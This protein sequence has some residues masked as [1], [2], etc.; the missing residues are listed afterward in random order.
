MAN[1]FYFW[2]R[3]LSRERLGKNE[4][5][6]LNDEIKKFAFLIHPRDTSDV[7]R[8]FWITRF[9]PNKLVDKIIKNLKRR[10]G[11]TLCSKFI[12]EKLD[13]RVE[14]YI[15]ATLLT[16]TQMMTLP[17]KTVRQRILDAI[18]FAQDKLEIELIGLGAL[19]ASVTEGGNWLLRQPKVKL[20]ITHG[21]TYAVAVAEEGIGK[22]LNICKFTPKNVKIAIVGAYGVIGREI[23]KF[24]AQKNTN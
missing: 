14:G 12:I 3:P 5:T 13:K 23:A 19:T 6:N 16:G 11:F 17:L 24:L 21:D 1:P 22:I 15:I 18:L 7:A 20:I 2:Q 8:R 10:L 4:E 9:L